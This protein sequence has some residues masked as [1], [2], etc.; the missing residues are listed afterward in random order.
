MQEVEATSMDL[1]SELNDAETRIPK[2]F[3]DKRLKWRDVEVITLL[4]LMM[5]HNLLDRNLTD[6]QVGEVLMEPMNNIGFER[7]SYQIQT[8]IKGLRRT[9]VKCV[10]AGCTKEALKECP[11]YDLLKKLYI[12]KTIDPNDSLDQKILGSEDDEVEDIWTKEELET[13]LSLIQKNNLQSKITLYTFSSTG[14]QEI[15]LA[16]E[17]HGYYKS[18]KEVEVALQSLKVTF[19]KFKKNYQR[20][21]STKDCPYFRYLNKMWGEEYVKTPKPRLR[22]KLK[23]TEIWSE[24]ETVM[25]LTSISE[26]DIVK[27][28]FQNTD[29]AAEKLVSVLNDSGYSR[30]KEQ[31]QRKMHN[32]MQNYLEG[33][34]IGDEA[35]VIHK[36]PFI[37]L[38]ETLFAPYF[39]NFDF[40]SFGQVESEEYIKKHTR[41]ACWSK[42]ETKTLLNLIIELKLA[43]DF[44]DRVIKDAILKLI[45][46]LRERGFERN[47]TQI[48]IKIK[49]L[50]QSYMRCIE[51]NC[52]PQALLECPF[53]NELNNIY[54]KSPIIHAPS[55]EPRIIIRSQK[56]I[57]E[58]NIQELEHSYVQFDRE[59]VSK[60]MKLT[61]RNKNSLFS[62]TIDDKTT[63][64]PIE[65]IIGK[66]LIQF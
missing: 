23:D 32:L 35:E 43:R 28:A 50:R 6:R 2:N 37:S 46:P 48:K 21:Q 59:S 31:L 3:G 54:G 42:K 13:M 24:E 61:A 49:S 65:T 26:L 14:L 27:E 15:S 19:I 20:G 11:F 44:R 7:T 12:R 38:Y 40:K 16:L 58:S 33:K 30:T 34:R 57:T 17:K 36:F 8:K 39:K 66:F 1:D 25:L 64:T 10:R 29:Y 41:G 51:A 62:G 5:K 53:Y 63:W 22:Y 4:E 45:E 60:A 47:F 18:I 52:T 56:R 9:Y 55:L